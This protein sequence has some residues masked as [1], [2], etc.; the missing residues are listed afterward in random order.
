MKKKKVYIRIKFPLLKNS[1]KNEQ[2]M[3]YF[4]IFS[5]FVNYS[6]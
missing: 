3:T 5:M 6:L 2:F 4:V 1:D